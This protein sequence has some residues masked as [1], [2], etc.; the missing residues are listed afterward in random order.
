MKKT[1]FFV[2]LLVIFN[3]QTAWSIIENNDIEYSIV[4]IL[5][6]KGDSKKV[7][8]TAEMI[9]LLENGGLEE[10]I[11]L[12]YPLDMLKGWFCHNNS[13]VKKERQIVCEG[14]YSAKMQSQE[15]GSTARI[16]QRIAVSPGQ[17][18]RIRF[19]Y[20]VEQWKDKGARTYC[21]FRTDAAEK[22]NISADE[23]KA[24]YGQEQY[25]TIRGGGYGKT[26]LPHELGIWQIFD[27]TVEVPPSAYFFVFGVNSYY[28]SIIYVDDCWVTDVTKKLI[29]GDVNDDGDVGIGDIVTITN[30]MAGMTNCTMLEKADV[31]GDGEVGIGDIVTITNIMAGK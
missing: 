14:N 17:K 29:I 18:I 21:Y 16:D 7:N 19:S 3:C 20:Y 4:Y 5:Q 28:G 10:W 1:D 24:F 31:N 8:Q 2:L 9:N 22:Y 30:Y 23:L 27:E 25:Y 6:Q 12:T 15:K 11:P 13:N 26:Y